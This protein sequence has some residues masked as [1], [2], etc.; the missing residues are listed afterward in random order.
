MKNLIHLTEV[1]HLYEASSTHDYIQCL[2]S[3]PN[4][5][6]DDQDDN[7]PTTYI[8]SPIG[9]I[10][11]INFSNEVLWT[12]DLNTISNPD[13]DTNNQ[14]KDVS[15]FRLS[16]EENSD[17]LVALS[18]S[19]AIVSID[20]YNTEVSELIGQFD[21]GISCADW[22]AD[23]ELLALVTFSF[24]EIMVND[25][26]EVA[27]DGKSHDL[28]KVP[29]LMTMNNQFEIL[30]EEHLSPISE[31]D[32][33]DMIHICWNQKYDNALVAVSSHDVEDNCR[34]IRIFKGDTLELNS[35]SRTEDGS[36]KLISNLMGCKNGNTIAWA[37]SNTS[38]ALA[39]V[40]KKGKR[41]RNIV[42]LEQNG[43]QHG[44]FK[45]DQR[46]DGEEVVGLHWN[47]ESDL[48]AITFIGTTKMEQQ[49]GECI[50]S[51]YG[52]LQLYHRNN[53]HWYLKSQ[54]QFQ[55]GNI[56]SDVQFDKVKGYDVSVGLRD[57]NDN[58]CNQEW[59]HYTF[60]WD[61]S[62]T[63]P[64]SGMAAVIDGSHL[65]L[66]MFQRAIV[67][68]P[69][70]TSRLSFDY[71][72][73]AVAHNP[74]NFSS[75]DCITHLS[76]G[77]IAFCG[78]QNDNDSH[79]NANC[80]TPVM[81][82]HFDLATLASSSSWDSSCLRQLMILN[83]VEGDN[84]EEVK[85]FLAAVLCSK[86]MAFTSLVTDKIVYFEVKLSRQSVGSSNVAQLVESEMLQLEGNVLRIVNWS[87][88]NDASDIILG[89]ALLELTDGSLFQLSLSPSDSK[90]EILPCQCE[91]MF[92]EPCPWIAG[93]MNDAEGNG[94][95]VGLS[96]RYRLYCG[97]RQLCDA[98]SS[99]CLSPATGFLSYVTLGSRSQLRFLPLDVLSSFDPFMGSDDNLELLG[100][101]YE[102]RNV[103]RGS[104]LV[105][106]LPNKITT[107]LQLPRGNLEAIYPRALVLP[108]I[109]TLIQEGEYHIALDMMRR[110]KVDMNLI[111]DMDPVRFLETNS[112]VKQMIEKVRKI[113]HLNLFIASLS[114][115]DYTLW[116]YPVPR[117]FCRRNHDEV[118]SE[119]KLDSPTFDFSLKINKVCE[120]MRNVMIDIDDCSETVEDK[121]LLPVLSTFAKQDPPKLEDALSLI[122][123][124]AMKLSVANRGKS[125]LLGD[126]AQSSIQYLAFLAD[127]EL[128]FNT[129]LGMYD[130]DLAKAVARNSQMDPKIYL[131]MVKRL[132]GLPMFVAKYEIDMKLKRYDSALIN[133]H[134]SGMS[135]T[136]TDSMDSI[137]GDHFNKCLQFIETHK[138]HRLG[139]EL[140]VRNTP[141][142]QQILVSLGELFLKE[143]KPDLALATFLVAEPKYYDGA[144]RA[145]RM[146]GDWK[147]FFSCMVEDPTS[148][149]E[150]IQDVATL[151]AEEVSSGRGGIYGR[152]ER[153]DA[154]ARILLDYC[155]DVHG[156]IDMLVSA[157]LWFEARRVALFHDD[158]DSAIGIVDSAVDY[159]HSCLT[160]FEER[161]E[162]F[163]EANSRYNDVVF[164]RRQAKLDG[165]EMVDDD[166]LETGSLFSLASN[167]SNSSMSSNMS[168][169]SVGSVSSLSSVISAG[170]RSTFSV[171]TTDDSTRH[172]SK[173]NK[174]GRKKKKKK[175][176]REKMRLKPGSEE[177][178]QSLVTKMKVN[179]IDGGNL[180]PITDTIKFLAQVNKITEAKTLYEAYIAFKD[181]VSEKQQSRIKATMEK[182]LEKEK[183]D[184]SEGKFYERVILDCENTVDQLC[185]SDLPIMLSSLF[186][187]KLEL[188]S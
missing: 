80:T 154:A 152:R 5:S 150:T 14:E 175:T 108:R 146:C 45:L 107:V 2:I 90:V 101:G 127:Y 76:N 140:F 105:S 179:V 84:A 159:S 158:L 168:S 184:R 50:E 69:M 48:L 79:L 163:E 120:K 124:N 25:A 67:P 34:K 9:K 55:G 59:R 137:D 128:L 66:S 44:G 117:W 70:Y 77:V 133:L 15:W 160:D 49:N 131:P 71:P 115:M 13:V 62:T 83:V 164:I 93:M 6:P 41:G 82:G 8:L 53:Y 75:I 161:A 171:I 126:R 85:V 187:F 92:L 28:I 148:S 21:H 4:A 177:E 169:S 178:L 32:D 96:N 156:A 176:R 91:S 149:P 125:I 40:Q 183:L 1:R 106:I 98:S 130:F 33:Q 151:V 95:V 167:A 60:A 134:K 58:A 20:P 104:R 173:F 54:I 78:N 157:E 26:D 10:S 46:L 186:L 155:D 68:P 24:V 88:A 174:I 113:D 132:K 136:D 99:F 119:D 139:L 72:V 38:N 36:G 42:F 43:L 51:N 27:E 18:H 100:E 166:N 81:L 170:A 102:P 19:G 94:I 74:T 109:M 180:Q 17:K 65:N 138:L 145:A 165:E 182:T 123:Q 142:H 35:M 122:K 31:K 3:N 47:S 63:A 103:E 162:Y 181:R 111:V 144:K 143:Q 153:K 57:I 73:I 11:A 56:I 112:G 116:K 97:E 16:Y 188:E 87:N 147:T 39:V 23:G 29:T 89:G 114:N 185:C 22:S 7:V 110:Q 52:K 172:K 30:A 12:L 118:H 121:F 141:W 37:G 129:S 61:C 64:R 86:A 135:L